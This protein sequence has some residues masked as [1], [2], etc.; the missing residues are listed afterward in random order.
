MLTINEGQ[1]GVCLKAEMETE[2]VSV[3]SIIRII[4]SVPLRINFHWQ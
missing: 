3:K 4:T 2:T 1:T